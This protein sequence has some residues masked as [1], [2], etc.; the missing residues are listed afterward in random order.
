MRFI[1]FLLLSLL[2]IQPSYAKTDVLDKTPE[3]LKQWA[4][5]VM[6]DHPNYKCPN[7]S[8]SNNRACIFPSKLTLNISKKS[9]TFN[10]IAHTKKEGW[11]SLIGNKNYWPQDVMIDKK[12]LPVVLNRATPSVYLQ[13]G[14]H[15]ITG[16][17]NWTYR[18]SSIPIPYN[19][20]LFKLTIDGKEIKHPQRN[21]EN[22]IA[23][24]NKQNIQP[25][26][27]EK[28]S[29]KVKVFRQI[30][31]NIPANITTQIK[32]TITGKKRDEIIPSPL[33]NGSVL[34]S[35]QAGGLQAHLNTD[36]NKLHIA[37][38]PGTWW[39]TLQERQ[40]SKLETLSMQ[41]FPWQ[42]ELWS[43]QADS[44]LRHLKVEGGKAINPSQTDMPNHWKRNATYL[45]KKGD[46][47]TF[48]EQRRGEEQV[49]ENRLQLHRTAWLGM[50]GGEVTISDRLSGTLSE[51]WDISFNGGELQRAEM[52]GVLQPISK[53]KNGET[54]VEVRKSNINLNT[55][56]QN[57]NGV[58]PF[59]ILT[60]PANGW[61]SDITG[62]STTINTAPGWKIM[63]I[64]SSG[65]ESN[66]WF[67]QWNLYD[68]FSLLLVA[69]AVAKLWNIKWG[70]FTFLSVGLIFQ[71]SSGLAAIILVIIATIALMRVIPKG[72]LFKFVRIVN[73]FT[74]LSFIIFLLP[75]MVEHIRYAI[76]PQLDNQ[77]M[78]GGMQKGRF[79]ADQQPSSLI[80]F[81]DRGIES[82][83]L[84]EHKRR[85]FAKRSMDKVMNSPMALSMVAEEMYDQAP[86]KLNTSFDPNASLPTGNGLPNW[87][88]RNSSINWSS[89]VAVNEEIT[90]WLLSPWMYRLVEILKV[91]LLGVLASRLLFNKMP[92]TWSLKG[93]KN[94]MPLLLLISLTF[95]AMPAKADIPSQQLLN[96]LKS[97]LMRQAE[98]LPNCA[99]YA[100][101]EL[102]IKKNHVELSL[103][104]V[105]AEE[106]V[107]PLPQ[108]NYPWQPSKVLVNEKDNA[109][110][111][112]SNNDLK[113]LLPAGKHSVSMVGYMPKSPDANFYFPL[114]PHQFAINVQGWNVEGLNHL[115]K[116]EKNLRLTKI[117]NKVSIKKD[118]NK[119]STAAEPTHI[120]P[121]A[122]VTRSLHLS[123]EWIMTTEIS[124][125][126][127]TGIEVKYPLIEG[128]Q[129]LNSPLKIIN[130][131]VI[132]PLSKYQRRQ[133]FHTIIPAMD[134]LK[135]TAPKTNMW[136]E[137]WVVTPSS[138]WNVR[139]EGISPVY[140]TRNNSLELKWRPFPGEKVA[141]GITK[142][143]NIAGQTLTLHYA[144]L[145]IH[146]GEKITESKLD[147]S[148]E[149][150]KP[151][152]YN[153]I[154]PEDAQ[155]QTIHIDN[156][157]VPLSQNGREVTVALPYGKHSVKAVWHEAADNIF[158]S[159]P[160]INLNIPAT[161]LKVR[162]HTPAHR[163][164]LMAFGDWGPAV[165]LWS[166]LLAY[167]ALSFVLAKV[168]FVPLK[169]WQWFLLVIGFSQ[170]HPLALI[171]PVGCLIILGLK[172]QYA[173][174]LGYIGFNALQVVL[175]ILVISALTGTLEA[176]R[177]GL[178]GGAETYITGNGSGKNLL[179]WYVDRTD[180]SM[181]N[182]F[183]MM[184]PSWLYQW[185]IML[186]WATWT[187][188]LFVDKIALWTWNCFSAHGYWK[189]KATMPKKK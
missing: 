95:V 79:F 147:M 101:G 118:P 47:L 113:I 170:V 58:S 160:D 50:D 31:D 29:I 57:K 175:V 37:V 150:T 119:K 136:H 179:Q 23:K 42:E 142:P 162:L 2:L 177:I 64:W 6:F 73:L 176:I 22:F 45:M 24:T 52:N 161:N 159:T 8:S 180:G 56:A 28:D 35:L 144:T 76:Y 89:P 178:L 11:V 90:I 130:G 117:K 91:V 132:V 137:N 112:R 41:N 127:G 16:K 169:G 146:P 17:I 10:L 46:V 165:L 43:F 30:Q 65:N 163:F 156:R 1:Y 96:Q 62:G 129:L 133:V 71:E 115:G 92:K 66:T 94:V 13:A 126:H 88:W 184:P 97:R 138:L 49:Q 87:N 51:S 21:G 166:I 44:N 33:L 60:L 151:Q 183:V 77:S 84:K 168:K 123:H 18:P 172:K 182:F 74:I 93:L 152:D 36:T 122:E 141:I 53:H 27:M 131:K 157:K 55:T 111:V 154:L 110:L 148:L 83:S 12:E 26:H 120:E 3:S 69:L 67:S 167:A 81:A 61:S 109:L 103:D 100:K 114:Q 108:L 139:H 19:V 105:V 40:T 70:I 15:N 181:P 106:S 5:W 25:L 140:R 59:G 187:A 9:A 145:N 34:S 85:N 78:Y 125:R 188:Y 39:L 14:N 124:L 4:E 134:I 75:F 128:E 158:M 107:V 48:K 80:G 149:T 98:C 86:R 171:I 155:L 174:K 135:L 189:K 38:K 68:V 32:L 102:T 153:F 63:G 164:T 185:V 104:V 82:D 173:D 99:D 116:V 186:F 72:K 121:Y 143:E 20:A 7:E 54:T